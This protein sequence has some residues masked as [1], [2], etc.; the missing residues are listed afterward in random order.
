MA[1]SNSELRKK[2]SRNPRFRAA[3]TSG[4]AYVIPGRNN[5]GQVALPQA[6]PGG[7]TS[8]EPKKAQITHEV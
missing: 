5:Q 2:L 4:R 6:N 8:E 3:E 7:L 1:L